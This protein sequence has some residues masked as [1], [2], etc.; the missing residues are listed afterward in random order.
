LVIPAIVTLAAVDAASAHPPLS[1]SVI[2]T[3]RVPVFPLP[4]AVQFVKPLGKVMAGV[5]GTLK[6]D[7]KTTVTVLPAVSAPA[8]VDVNPTVHV[9]VAPA[10]F[11]EPENDT[12]VGGAT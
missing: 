3:V 11:G 2:V 8:E 6:P 12:A 7:G 4:V 9:E 5:V 10:V 1:T